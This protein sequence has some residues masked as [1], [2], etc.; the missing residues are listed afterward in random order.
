MNFEHE[1][2][3]KDFAQVA[4]EADEVWE[5]LLSKIQVSGGTER[6]K[7]YFIL[8]CIMLLNGRLYEVM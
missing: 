8:A 5:K 6:E 1:M 4:C 3:H 7:A 2:L